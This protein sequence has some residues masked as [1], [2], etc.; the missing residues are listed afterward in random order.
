MRSF[1][2]HSS[3][4]GNSGFT[5]IEIL[6]AT[7]ILAF[8][9]MLVYNAILGSFN[10]N[11]KL[12]RESDSYLSLSIAMQ[13]MERDVSQLFSPAMGVTTPPQDNTPEA[14]WSA[15]QREDGLR[16]SRFTG[17]KEKMS[18]VAMSN[19]RLQAEVKES[20]IL[21]VTYRIV[22]EKD[23]S[24]SV[25]RV[26]DADAFAYEKPELGDSEVNGFK[27]LEK[28][29]VATFGYYRGDKQRWEEQWDSEA[30]YTDDASRFPD[31]VAIEVQYASPDSATNILKWRSEFMP[32][33]KLNGEQ[34]QGANIG[35]GTDG[36]GSGG[37]GDGSNNPDSGT[38]GN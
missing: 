3:K 36:T 20:E 19:R 5:L 22:Q 8:A 11:R 21:R 13:A 38:G 24:Y 15:P 1:A 35:G 18:F 4:S 26:T 10:V 31:I 28:L 37:S 7:A 12:T 30:P 14:Y 17:S 33:L 25:V 32:V 9:S 27:V 6:V 29:T 23:G 2:R 16:R 34:K